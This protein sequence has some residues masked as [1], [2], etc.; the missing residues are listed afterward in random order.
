MKTEQTKLLNP[1]VSMAFLLLG[2]FMSH[3]L[4]AQ[5]SPY[6]KEY[7]ERLENS[8]DYLLLVAEKMPEDTYSF[9]ATPDTK[10]FE[11]ILMHIGWAMDWHCQSLLGDRPARDWKT[12]TELK[13][14]GK[15][16][17]QMLAKIEETFETTIAFIGNFDPSGLEETLD[18]FG[19]TRTKR[20]I[21]MLLADHITHH[22]GQMLVYL[23]LNGITP[24]R[25]IPFQ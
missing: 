7:L 17:T 15:T 12:D 24:P 16:K 5:K 11:E 8:K 25:Y 14:E 10:S 22:R 20:Q 6:I 13:P 1:L 23:R 19:L 18:Y 2:L 4:L 3:N 9:K 21:L